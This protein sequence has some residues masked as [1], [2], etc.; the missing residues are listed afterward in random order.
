MEPISSFT[1]DNRFL[2][3]FWYVD[4]LYDGVVYPTV[5]HAYQAAKTIDPAERKLILEAPTPGKAKQLGGKVT[6]RQGW[7]DIKVDVMRLL[8]QQ[9]FANPKLQA[10]LIATGDVELIEGN[11]W[12]DVFWGQCPIGKGQNHLGKLLME[13]RSS[14]SFMQLAWSS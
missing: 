9:K 8:L 1:K 4:V 3:N 6:M 12:G 2:S 10:M 7:D 13:I 5:E 11:T 14:Y